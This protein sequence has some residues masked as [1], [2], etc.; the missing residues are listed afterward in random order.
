[1]GFSSKAEIIEALKHP[2]D[3]TPRDISEC[4]LVLA[5]LFAEQHQQLSEKDAALAR[6]EGELIKEGKTSAAA[7]QEAKAT[8]FGSASIILKGEVEGTKELINA[9][10]RAQQYLLEEMKYNV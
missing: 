2:Y 5:A 1:M 4:Y 6:Y 8:D 7:K 9:L 10:K 3:L